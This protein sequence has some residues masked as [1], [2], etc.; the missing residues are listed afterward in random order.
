VIYVGG[1]NTANMLAV[2]R[3][4]GVDRALAEAW[5][6]GVVLCG[7]STGAICWFECGTTD[8]FGPIAPL[9]DGLGFLDGSACPHYDTEPQRRPRYLELVASG[10]PG[11]YAIEDHA[12]VHFEGT[13]LEVAVAATPDAHAFRV[14]AEEGRSLEEPL[15]IRYLG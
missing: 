11:G 13:E 15:D 14:R 4:H 6:Q 7:T 5:E 9:H 3:V 8:S 2:W 10:F 1:G 12:A